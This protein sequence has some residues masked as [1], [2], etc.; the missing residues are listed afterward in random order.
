MQHR[1][2]FNEGKAWRASKVFQLVYANICGPMNMTSI[3]GAGYFLLLVG[4]YSRKMWV[5][6][7]MLKSEVFVEF[8]IFKEL[9]EKEF[10]CPI[11]TLRFD[12]GKEL[13]SKEFKFF[14]A[15]HGI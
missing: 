12:N 3:T 6:F 10:G 15:N 4:G 7:V 2:P 8:Q 1:M 11:T 5:S 13:C 14:C 9:V